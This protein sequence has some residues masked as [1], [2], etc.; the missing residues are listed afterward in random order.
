MHG[1][2]LNLLR[3][4]DALLQTGSVAGAAARLGI[5]AS[6]MSRTLERIRQTTADPILVKA[7]RGLV[8]TPRALAIRSQV[9]Q[10]LQDAQALLS[11]ADYRHPGSFARTLVIRA[12][13]AVAAAFGGRLQMR[14]AQDAP[15]VQLTFQDEGDEDVNALRDG[16]VDL[17][18]GVQGALGPEIRTSPLFEDTRVAL[19]REQPRLRRR[20][21]SLQ[22][23]AERPHIDV[24]R[25]GRRHGPLDDALSKRNLQRKVC[26]VVPSQLTAA[27]LV[28]Q[29]PDAVS[30]ISQRFATF[31]RELLPVRGLA[32]PLDLG[33]AQVALAWHPRFD[34]D[35]VH[36]WL[37]QAIQQLAKKQF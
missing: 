18:I 37:R 20:T 27:A 10:A 33:K 32:L 23:L 35:P 16:R 7:G 15:A 11:P 22:A 34:G 24:S 14:I 13:A 36:R 8:P 17:D 9:R 25:R 6:A 4:L 2:D 3:A 12:D 30:L 21:L 28:A 26:L 31:A 29:L 5:S 19:V 1:L